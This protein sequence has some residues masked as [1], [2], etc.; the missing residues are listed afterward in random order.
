MAEGSRDA[1]MAREPP[2]SLGLPRVLSK[3][4]PRVLRQPALKRVSDEGFQTSLLTGTMSEEGCKSI[5]NPSSA[6][7]ALPETCLMPNQ[8]GRGTRVSGARSLAVICWWTSL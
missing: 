2:L 8:K 4:L 6:R 5:F 7:R 3:G 1:R